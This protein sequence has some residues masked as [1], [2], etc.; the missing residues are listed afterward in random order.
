MTNIPTGRFVWFEY[1][2]KDLK[3]SQGFFGELFNWSTQ[4][5]PMPQGAYTMIASNGGTIGGYQAPM[6]GGPDAA[7]LSHLQVKDA[8]ASA[9]QVAA[10]GGKVYKDAFDVHGVGVMAIVADPLGGTFALWQPTNRE[11]GGDY[12]GK[13]GS[14]CWNEL[15]TADPEASVKFYQAIGG[16]E[17]EAMEMP[18]M[19]KYHVLKKDGQSRAGVLKS[20]M[21]GVPQ[22]WLPYVAVTNCDTSN[23]KAKK[24]GATSLVPPTSVPTVGRFAVLK[25]PSGVA[26]GILQGA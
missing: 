7:W 26:I 13:A 15:Y 23:D 21:P 25:D 12:A 6:A 11:P 17:T 19:G 18:G 14:F 20:P 10:L 5:I 24:L 22:S 4:D 8:A 16:F 2:S 1:T 9:K 3:K